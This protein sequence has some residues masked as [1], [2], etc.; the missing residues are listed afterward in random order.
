[1]WFTAPRFY[2]TL[3]GA[4]AGVAVLLAA[5][6]VYGVISYSVE[7]RRHEIG[8]RMALGASR[9]EA[10]GLVVRQGMRL[11]IIGAAIGLAGAL[12][13]TRWLRS[14][15]FGVSASDPVTFVA[16]VLVLGVIALVAC[17]IPARRAAR[18]DPA[19]ALRAE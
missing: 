11:A 4:F 1:Q 7:R 10:F 9:G 8:V 17:T 6:G 12:L 13:A 14:L 2:L 5:I 19:T 18:V 16:V 15:L 3:L